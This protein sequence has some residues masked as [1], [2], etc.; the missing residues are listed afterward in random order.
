MRVSL[1]GRVLGGTVLL[2]AALPLL[3]ACGG[4]SGGDKPADVTQAELSKSL[5]G[6]GLDAAFAD[7]AAKVFMDEGISQAGL[8]VMVKKDAKTV[9]AADYEAAGMSKADSDKA[10]SAA[11]KI[12]SSCMKTGS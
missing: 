12:V 8:Q 3:V 11:T 7:C 9:G 2:A 6:G 4:S 1:G 5:Q 10:Q